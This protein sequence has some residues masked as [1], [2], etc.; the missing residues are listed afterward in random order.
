MN[1]PDQK[2][3][4][5]EVSSETFNRML[6]LVGAVLPSI[7]TVL[8]TFM[9]VSGGLVETWL[10]F[11]A[12]KEPLEPATTFSGETLTPGRAA[13]LDNETA[14]EKSQKLLRISLSISS[15][16]S[17]GDFESSG[18]LIRSLKEEVGLMV[19]Y[20]GHLD[21]RVTPINLSEIETNVEATK[22]LI[23]SPANNPLLPQDQKNELAEIALE[24]DKISNIISSY[25]AETYSSPSLGKLF[26]YI[27]IA[28]AI[29]TTFWFSRS[30]FLLLLKRR[31]KKGEPKED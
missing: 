24:L 8:V 26:L 1:E 5:I 3:N 13:S 10:S 29:I 12:E 15:A 27:I 25:I 7:T 16:A 31:F 22:T 11:R 28:L 2:D 23:E 9:T 14:E 17:R 20:F 21:P 4:K 6:L 18:A 19:F 30:L